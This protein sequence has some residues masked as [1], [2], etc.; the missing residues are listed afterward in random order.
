MERLSYHIEIYHR[1]GEGSDAKFTE[2]SD[3]TYDPNDF[4]GA[5]EDQIR[6]DI[7]IWEKGRNA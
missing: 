3:I 5:L 4:R 6:A 1:E 2:V 7:E